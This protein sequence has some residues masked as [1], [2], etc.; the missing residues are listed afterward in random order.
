MY[1]KLKLTLFTNNKRGITT[2]NFL[3]KKG[4]NIDEVFVAKKNLDKNIL[5]QIKKKNLKFNLIRNLKEKKIF[6]VLKKTDIALICG[7]PLIFNKKHL[8]LPKY[9][10]LNQHA[11]ILPNYRGGS[12]LN[13]Q[14]I[15]DE[16]YFGISV[17]K[18]NEKID[19]GDIVIDKKFKL[20]E[21]Y[22]IED[23]HSIANKNFGNL[24]LQAI[25]LIVKN[26]R[27]KKQTKHNAKY[28]KQR[29]AKDSCFTPKKMTYKKLVLLDR[30][31]SKSYH[32]PYFILDSKKI[33]INKFKK[34][35]KKK[36]RYSFFNKSK[37]NYLKLTD[38]II[39]FK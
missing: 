33:I 3:K 34:L 26:S 17:I 2:F 38:S 29:N 16:K 32:R 5:N 6:K 24:T 18:I 1:K 13:W 11:G 12:P 37:K 28:F 8:K 14:I 31:V 7:F 39:E 4:V 30:A 19:E 21:K 10:Y 23:L 35:N 25:S 27:L 15:N 9:G 20:L 22:K 36:F